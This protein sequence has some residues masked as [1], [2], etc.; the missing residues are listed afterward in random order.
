MKPTATNAAK[1]LFVLGAMFLSTMAMPGAAFAKDWT[2]VV[3]NMSFGKAPAGLEVGDT[4]TWINRD[5]V[6]HTVTAR[7]KSF[8]LAVDRGASVKVTLTKAGRLA[9]YCLFHPMMRGTLTVASK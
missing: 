8:N 6:P 9:Y 5:S 7:D 4:V 2:I 1:R 3:N